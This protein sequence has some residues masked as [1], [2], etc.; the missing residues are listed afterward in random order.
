[1]LLEQEKFSYAVMNSKHRK[2]KGLT[3]PGIKK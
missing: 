3:K 2:I 1:M